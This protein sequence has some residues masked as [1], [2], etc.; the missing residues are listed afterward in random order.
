M[1]MYAEIST[2]SSNKNRTQGINN[3]MIKTSKFTMKIKYVQKILN[4]NSH[5]WV[6]IATQTLLS[7]VHDI[8]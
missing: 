4:D 5:E 6:Q 2:D 8:P 1:P 7:V 3:E